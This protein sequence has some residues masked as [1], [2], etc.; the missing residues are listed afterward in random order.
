MS[1]S[2]RSIGFKSVK[3]YAVAQVD[4]EWRENDNERG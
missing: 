3:S 1:S 2:S 4:E